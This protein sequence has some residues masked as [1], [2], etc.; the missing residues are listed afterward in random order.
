MSALKITGLRASIPGREILRG[1]D[2]EVESGQVHAVMG[3]NGSGK[4][5]LSHVLMGRPGYE[6][7]GGSVTIDGVELLE[8][9]TWKRA[10]AGLFLALQYPIEVPGVSLA[11]MFAESFAAAGRDRASVPALVTAE[12]ERIGFDA[13]FLTR[14][15]NVD[16]SGGEKKRNETLQLGL[17]RPKFAILDEIDSGLDVDALRAVARRV[18]AETTETGLGVLAITHY[19]RLLSELKPDVVHVL[20]GG[21]IVAT[22]GAELADELERTGYAGYVEDDA[23]VEVMAH[24]DDPFADH[25]A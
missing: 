14:P 12:A 4:S 1:I 13:R 25:L 8:L 16:L 2:L 20:S 6:V 3:P 24:L 5:T 17:L 10:Q 11:D 23:E 21:R 19:S 15:L 22:G 9:P 18:E 7:T